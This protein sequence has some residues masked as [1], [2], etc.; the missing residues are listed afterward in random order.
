MTAKLSL[1]KDKIKILLLEGVNQTAPSSC[2]T[3]AGYE[4]V[5]RLTKALDGANCAR[6]CRAC[7]CS[8]SARAP[9]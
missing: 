9:S 4:N 6:R 7:T 2:S 1:P 5:T 8:A 3:P